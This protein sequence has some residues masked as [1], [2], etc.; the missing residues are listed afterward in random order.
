VPETVDV[1]VV[2][3]VPVISLSPV[4]VNDAVIPIAPSVLTIV[5]VAEPLTEE[6]SA[7]ADAEAVIRFRP[8]TPSTLELS[9]DKLPS[10]DTTV[11]SA[12]PDTVELSE[13][14]EPELGVVR[15]PVPLED[16]LPLEIELEVSVIIRSAVPET[17]LLSADT[18]ADTTTLAVNPEPD[19]EE[20]KEEVEPVP[21]TLRSP[22]PVNDAVMPKAPSVDTTVRVPVAATD[23]L[24][25]TIPED[26]SISRST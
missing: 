23:E 9:A 22:V 4:P 5:L 10:V 17:E 20:F 2:E 12:V 21:V 14:R 16:E 3:P 26:A 18:L 7:S 1:A 25:D 6:L 11:L 15:S 24:P 19:V 13:T 8:P